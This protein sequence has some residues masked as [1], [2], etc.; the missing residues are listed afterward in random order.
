MSGISPSTVYFVL[1]NAHTADIE[2]LSP[3]CLLH[4]IIAYLFICTTQAVLVPK[5]SVKVLT[6]SQLLEEFYHSSSS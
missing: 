5:Q 3:Y 4:I 1:V 2:R 6:R